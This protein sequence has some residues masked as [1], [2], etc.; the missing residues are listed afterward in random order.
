MVNRDVLLKDAT[1]GVWST[2][3]SLEM[4][5]GSDILFRNRSG[6]TLS[7]ATYGSFVG[8]GY[9]STRYVALGYDQGNVVLGDGTYASGLDGDNPI[10][11]K[12]NATNA[13]RELELKV[14]TTWKGASSDL[15]IDG[16]LLNTA[17]KAMAIRE[18]D[19]CV[20]GVAK[21]MLVLSSAPY[22]P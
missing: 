14:K 8:W 18:I 12:P 6:S 11:Y 15:V 4:L 16:T 13:S 9:S 19:V 17:G 2:A 3:T 22:D 10:T 1:I 20:D 7:A 5:S 21:K